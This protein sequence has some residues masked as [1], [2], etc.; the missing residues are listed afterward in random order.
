M[1]QLSRKKGDFLK[2][3]RN[4]FVRREERE[5][6]VCVGHAFDTTITYTRADFL[7]PSA[8]AEKFNLGDRDTAKKLMQ[9]AKT[10]HETFVLKDHKAPVIVK[11]GRTSG[12]YLHPMALEAFQRF[13]EKQRT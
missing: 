9:Q 4:V 13:I 8:V 2:P 7:P 6:Y 1:L 5:N 12:L 11:F 3:V 10:A